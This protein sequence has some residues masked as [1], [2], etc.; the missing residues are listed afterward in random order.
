MPLLANFAAWTPRM[1][2]ALRR[3]LF[4]QIKKR[5]GRVSFGSVFFVPIKKMNTPTGRNT[6]LKISN[7]LD[8]RRRTLP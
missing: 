6:K 4:I 1:S 3:L 5:L 8:E 2:G 7:R